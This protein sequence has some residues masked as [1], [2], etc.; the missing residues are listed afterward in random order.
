VLVLGAACTHASK[1]VVRVTPAGP[2]V[3]PAPGVVTKALPATSLFQVPLPPPDH[4]AADPARP[5]VW[6][7]AFN[8]NNDPRAYFWDGQKN[9]LS[10]WSLGGNPNEL[11]SGIQNGIAVGRDGIVWIGANQNLV[12]LDPRSGAVSRTVVPTP[13]A[14]AAAESFRPPNLRGQH[15]IRA[16]AVD[17][18]KHVA[19]ALSAA[20]EVEVLDTGPMTFSHV[21]LPPN[22]EPTGVSYTPDGTLGVAMAD[23]LART[24]SLLLANANGQQKTLP[25]PAGSIGTGPGSANFV[26]GRGTDGKVTEVAPDGS[27]TTLSLG[28]VSSS[29]IVGGDVISVGKKVASETTSGF[30]VFT[31]G[32]PAAEYQFPQTDCGEPSRVATG[33]QAPPPTASP[34]PEKCG[35]RAATLTA[36]STGQLYYLESA[37]EPI[38]GHITP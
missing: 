18:S 31:P 5:G 14:S 11:I 38:V 7:F 21:R 34:T 24:E 10:S 16:V 23:P 15:A 17:G 30:V 35:H 27:T 12:R 1:Q 9:A 36:D 19:V 13:A 33:P 22:K 32:A 6:F 3:P 28:A 8:G 20:Q 26:V 2:L 37:P 29:L 4:L 25:T